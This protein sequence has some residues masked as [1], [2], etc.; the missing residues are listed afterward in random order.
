MESDAR[1]GQVAVDLRCE[2]L[3]LYAQLAQYRDVLATHAAAHAAREERLR[4][5]LA[6]LRGELWALRAVAGGGHVT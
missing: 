4:D 6:R 3:G 1:G 5:E 2:L